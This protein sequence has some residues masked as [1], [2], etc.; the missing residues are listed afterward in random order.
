MTNRLTALLVGLAIVL[1]F[2][3]SSMY[4]VTPRQQAVVLRF[5]QIH[6]VKSD[7]G[8]YFKM[9]FAFMQFDR[10]QY[11]EN[12]ARR[13][14]Y[15]NIRAQVSGGK[16]YEVD[17]FLVYR[18]TDARRFLAAASGVQQ[19]AEDRLRTRFNSSLR[20][21]YGL[22][23]FES[24][25]SDARASM[26]QEVRDDLRPD[27]EALGL[28]IVD[29]R[30]RRTDLSQDVSLDTFKRMR[31]ERLAEAELIRARGNEEA[32]RR[33]AIADRQVVELESDARRQSEVLRGEGDAERN[34]I[35]GEAFQRDPSFFEF[36]RSMGA[37]TTALT[38]TGT[39]LVLSPDSPFFRYFNDI[40]GASPRPTPPAA[41]AAAP[42]N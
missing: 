6:D 19:V 28:S 34:R 40:N 21:V 41:P 27:A 29:V 11:V 1:F 8:V 10:V 30:I 5:N 26:M 12:R 22:R 38:G 36:Y 4:I 35:F 39:T 14:D 32:Q 42:A 7:P 2:L 9:P 13:L 37:Y 31:S 23:G 24:A 33:R 17:A 18:I 25:L 20:R 16:F 3:Y 15:E